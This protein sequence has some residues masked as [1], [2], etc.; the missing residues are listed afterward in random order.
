MRHVAP[1]A[2]LV[3]TFLIP[4]SIVQRLFFEKPPLNRQ[5]EPHSK[6]TY[7]VSLLWRN[8]PLQNAADIHW[9]TSVLSGKIGVQHKFKTPAAEVRLYS[10]HMAR[11]RNSTLRLRARPSS[12]SLVATG[13]LF[14]YPLYFKRLMSIPFDTRKSTT[15]L[16]RFSDRRWL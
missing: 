5:M 4:P 16:A 12:V 1:S 15:A 3:P 9:R 11:I 8:A 7:A 10:H 6:T 13:M 2:C 14:P